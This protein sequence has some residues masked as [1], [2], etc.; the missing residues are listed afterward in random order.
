MLTDF[1][2]GGDAVNAGTYLQSTCTCSIICRK[3]SLHSCW[4]Y[5]VLDEGEEVLAGRTHCMRLQHPPLYMLELMNR[6][7]ASALDGPKPNVLPVAPLTFRVAVASANGNRLP[8]LIVVPRLR[9]SKLRFLEQ[10]KRLAPT[11]GNLNPPE[12]R[13]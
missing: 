9:R 11:F 7:K 6:T 2:I 8:L 10:T 1:S 13:Q 5:V 12:R 3:E 4:T